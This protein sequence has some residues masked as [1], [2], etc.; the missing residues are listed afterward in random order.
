MVKQEDQ[1]VRR[2]ARGVAIGVADPGGEVL[3]QVAGRVADRGLVGHPVG[4]VAVQEQVVGE[5][6]PVPGRHRADLVPAIRVERDQHDVG[7]RPPVGGGLAEVVDDELPTS[8]CRRQHHDQGRDH[9]IVFL[10]VLVREEE[11]TL[12][13]DQQGMQVGGQP[14]MLRQPELLAHGIELGAEPQAAR[15][16]GT[17]HLPGDLPRVADRGIGERLLPPL[18][19]RR[20]PE[21]TQPAS[22]VRGHRQGDAADDLHLQVE[23]GRRLGPQLDTRRQ[24]ILG[25]QHAGQPF[26]RRAFH[27][28]APSTARVRLAK[29]QPGPQLGIRRF[30]LGEDR[31]GVA[32]ARPRCCVQ[33]VRRGTS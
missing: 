4:R 2:L 22:L 17:N 3:T 16:L 9:R 30:R 13:V 33:T 25:G 28:W 12:L 19:G 23:V 11:L 5:R 14:A 7:R 27:P 26:T 1:A 24:L 32:G 20:T 10:G 29:L 6:D 21:A 31:P 18:V 15:P 8:V